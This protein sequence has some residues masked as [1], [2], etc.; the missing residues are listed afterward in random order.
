LLALPEASSGIDMAK[1]DA[2][3]LI[4]LYERQQSGQLGHGERAGDGFR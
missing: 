1:T 2:P 3:S 4:E